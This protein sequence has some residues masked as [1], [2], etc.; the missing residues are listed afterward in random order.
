MKK[1]IIHPNNI[2]TFGNPKNGEKY[3]FDEC[4][5][6][7]LLEIKKRKHK[8][9]LERITWIDYDDVTQIIMIH[10]HEK[11]EMCDQSKEILKWINKIITNQTLNVIRNV[12]GN[13]RSICSQCKAN[14]GGGTC[15]IYGSTQNFR[16]PLYEDWIKSKK[17]YK[18]AVNLPTSFEELE[19]THKSQLVT[20][21]HS[22][23][24]YNTDKLFSLIK[25]LLTDFQYK[26]FSWMYIDNLDD[27]EIVKKLG[28]K[29]SKSVGRSNGYKS[30]QKLKKIFLE[31]AKEVI[32]VNDI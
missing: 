9:L 5:D 1:I 8:W 7:F 6:H 32:S 14:E 16:C 21:I 18:E 28:Y 13:Y 17:V 2:I 31:K 22:F 19:E 15:R 20:S 27:K 29:E 12:W 26:V 11:W 23:Q 25:P 24:N 10:L 30:I 3:T 4:A